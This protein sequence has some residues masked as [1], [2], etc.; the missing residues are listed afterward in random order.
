MSI[1]D[2]ERPAAGLRASE[3]IFQ[4]PSNRFSARAK[5]EAEEHEID[6]RG[7]RCAPA[8]ADTRIGNP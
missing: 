8:V 2:E 7:S 5:Q 3:T 6:G 1:V 4:K